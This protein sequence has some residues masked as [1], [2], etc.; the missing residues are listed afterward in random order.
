MRRSSWNSSITA[1]TLLGTAALSFCA[2]AAFAQD[3]GTKA[4]ALEPEEVI[5]TGTRI[6]NAGYQAPTPVTAVDTASL[7]TVTPSTIA[8]GLK[9]LPA[10]TGQSALGGRYYCCAAGTAAAGAFLELRQ[11]GPNRTLVL[12]N[13]NRIAPSTSSGVVDVN[14]LPE[15]LLQRVEV[16]TG[17]ASA[18]YGS[19]AVAGVVNYISDNKFD[20]LRANVQ[21]GLSR[22]SDDQQI[23]AGIAGGTSL[24]QGRGNLVVSLEHYKADGIDTLLERP[25]SAQSWVLAG[26]GTAASP[27][28]T[29]PNTRFYTG[30]NGGLIVGSYG[31]PV[32]ISNLAPLAGT[33]FL[34][35]GTYGPTNLGT[36]LPPGA[37]NA[38]GGDGYTPVAG[39]QPL[40]ELETNRLFARF[41]YE[42]SPD[43][44]SYVQL[45][46]AVNKMRNM[47]GFP[48]FSGNSATLIEIFS[49]N[50]YIP[51]GLQATMT[52]NSYGSFFMTR[53]SREGGASY[54]T[55]DTQY[56][57][58]SA[59][60]SGAFA[61]D[62]TWD[63][64]VGYGRTEQ[65]GAE[66]NAINVARLLAAVDVVVGPTGQPVCRVTLTSPGSAYDGCVPANLFG[67]GSPSAAA[68]NY[69]TGTN[70]N[71][72][73][74]SE[75]MAG[76]NFQGQLFD[77]PAG[78]VS[79]ATGVEWRKRE[80]SGTSNGVATAQVVPATIRGRSMNVTLCPTPTSCRYGGWIQGN[81]GAQSAMSDKVQELYAETSAPILGTLEFNGA[82]RYTD[83][84]NSG[85]VTT[86]KAG[87]TFEPIADIK[88]RTSL[89]RDIRAPNLYELF[90]SP[91]T[92]FIAFTV[93]PF[94][95]RQI[96]T[97]PTITTGNPALKPETGD[98][99][100]LGVVLKPSAL[101]GLTASI[102]YYSI[103]LKNGIVTGRTVTQL[104]TAC[105]NGD[106][107]ACAQIVGTPANDAITSVTLQQTNAAVQ[108]RAGIDADV[109]YVHPVAG[110][111]LA[112]RLLAGYVSKADS[113]SGGVT[114]Q[115][116]GLST[117]GMPEWRGQLSATFDRGPFSLTV[118][119]RYIGS[120]TKVGPT[121]GGVFVEPT[122]PA[123]FY[124]NISASYG[125]ELSGAKMKV[126]GTV[127]NLLDREPPLLPT[128]LAGVGYPTIPGLYDLDGRYFTLGVRADW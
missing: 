25:Q 95:G 97:I 24:L 1:R 110:G 55:T 42:I 8:E 37:P 119:E 56:Y 127:N 115:Y 60:L 112:L 14:V 64:H 58:L 111:N 116:V 106:A 23:K 45:T 63:A 67:V 35:G 84:S 7:L 48:A 76:I 18:A 113:I 30:T 61:G 117:P 118:Q 33:Q 105:F 92:G 3:Q 11:L 34:P 83:Y 6:R 44:D 50:P 47:Y 27:Y 91:S 70:K 41:E 22:Y 73:T 104:L 98:T 107:T 19:D 4:K 74:S 9:T 15:L 126:Y 16:V 103:R 46:G 86:W 80:L 75:L 29:V 12:L 122:V 49:G 66:N 40:G 96:P 87:L 125:F 101:P 65:D 28:Y 13:G 94:T 90:A 51:A 31:L 102:D 123:V 88:F 71:S 69:Y 128:T 53:S 43:L 120:M 124:T 36:A 121:G 39:M 62:W 77:L 54:N 81:V 99:S 78:P 32:N 114:T 10:L 21:Y 79:A 17:G 59:G 72:T 5:V 108:H 85:G 20:G 93:N 100:T 82:V 2:G 26:A 38:E 89:S 68:V 109:T 57:D 52:A